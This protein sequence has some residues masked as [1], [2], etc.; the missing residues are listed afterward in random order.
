MPISL[1]KIED[2]LASKGFIARKFFTLEDYCIYIEAFSVTNASTFMLYVSSRYELKIPEGENVWKLKYME[3]NPDENIISNYA[4][5][6]SNTDIQKYYNDYDI[7]LDSEKFADDLENKLKEHYNRPLLLKDLSKEDTKNLKD[8][9][10]QMTRFMYCVQNIKYKLSIFYKNY[11]VSITK[12]D[13]LDCF[14]IYDYPKSE[15]QQLLI[16]VD[17]KTFFAKQESVT[18]DIPTIKEAIQHLL[19]QNQR[20]HTKLLSEMLEQRV[21]IFQIS[22]IVEQKKQEFNIYIK[23]YQDCLQNINLSEK[24]M[25]DKI[26]DIKNTYSEYSIKGLHYDIERTHLMSQ[27]EKE[28]SQITALKQQII[29]NISSIRIKHEN[30]TLKMDRILFDNSIMINEIS[31]N[32]GKLGEFLT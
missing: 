11:L 12:D 24:N 25:L 4:E 1:S 6:P 23:E 26:Q 10:R 5:E 30:I 28:L 18:T 2:L 29:D 31:K 14:L 13:E 22:S 21:S 20:K 8:I 7:E 27:Y 19:D 32:F 15:E 3:M 16:Y 17:L 9:F